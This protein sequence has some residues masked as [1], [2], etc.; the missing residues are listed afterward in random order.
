[1]QKNGL[2]F[3]LSMERIEKERLNIPTAAFR[4]WEQQDFKELLKEAMDKSAFFK[5]SPEEDKVQGIGY[6]LLKCS[7]SEDKSIC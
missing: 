5:F 1:M 4:F 2:Y 3:I 6:L 7:K